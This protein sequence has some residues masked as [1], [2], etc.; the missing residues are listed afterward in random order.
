M[1]DGRAL[2][3]RDLGRGGELAIERAND[4]EPHVFVPY[5]LMAPSEWRMA[6]WRMAK[7]RMAKWRMVSSEG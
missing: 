3:H 5:S 7:W 6:K 4:E 2:V 1:S